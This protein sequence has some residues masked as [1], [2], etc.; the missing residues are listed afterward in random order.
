MT[1]HTRKTERMALR[2]TPEDKAE[3]EAAAEITGTAASAFVVASARREARRL[4]S[5]QTILTLDPERWAAFTELLDRPAMDK[6][7]LRKLLD[8]PAPFERP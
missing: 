8:A 7:L 2:V 5:E 6:P 4:R 1:T 3:F